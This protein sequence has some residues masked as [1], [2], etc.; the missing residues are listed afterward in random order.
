M[1]GMAVVGVPTDLRARFTLTET[2][3]LALAVQAGNQ[4]HHTLLAMI[5]LTVMVTVLATKAVAFS[6]QA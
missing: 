5:Y 4:T 2:P 1:E 6:A 3:A